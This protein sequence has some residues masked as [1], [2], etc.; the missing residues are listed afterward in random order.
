M[1]FVAREVPSV[2]GESGAIL[3]VSVFILFTLVFLTMIFA[4]D[5]VSPELETWLLSFA[6]LWISAC[7]VILVVFRKYSWID[8]TQEEVNTRFLQSSNVPSTPPTRPTNNTGPADYYEPE[9]LALKDHSTSSDTVSVFSSSAPKCARPSNLSLAPM[10]RL[11]SAESDCGS[12]R[13]LSDDAG[14]NASEANEHGHSSRTRAQQTPQMSS[15][16]MPSALTD[17]LVARSANA[18]SPALAAAT[19]QDAED[20]GAQPGAAASAPTS[21]HLGGLSSEP[22][23][24]ARPTCAAQAYDAGRPLSDRS[25]A[26]VRQSGFAVAAENGWEEYVDRETGDSFFI[27]TAT[28]RITNKSPSSM[29]IELQ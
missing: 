9:K 27:H 17:P 22:A 1:A 26:R 7:Y 16:P 13:P 21:S 23:P 12:D 5:S 6:V 25:L 20:P 29:D 14:N 4:I 19:D 28:G 11:Q 15:P 2:G 18:S 8:A 3:Y 24:P 10:A